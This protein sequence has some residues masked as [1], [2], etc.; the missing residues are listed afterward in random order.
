[1]T[2]DRFKVALHRAV[3][4]ENDGA[5]FEAEQIYQQ[6]LR[7]NANI[8]MLHYMYAQFLL[9]KGEYRAAWPHFLKRVEDTVYKERSAARLSKPYWDARDPDAEAGQTI[10]IYADQGLGDM[11]MCA[12]FLPAVAARFEKTV[13]M[14][15]PG[16]RA[17]LSS[18]P[19][20]IE[21]I[22]FGDPLPAFDVHADLFS[23]PALLDVLPETLPSPKCLSIDPSHIDAW[24]AGLDPSRLNVGLCWRGNPNHMRDAERSARL[25]DFRP[26]LDTGAVFHCLQ[27]GDAL[28]EIDDLPDTL[29]LVV[30]RKISESVDA[31]TGKM[32]DTAALASCMDLVISVDTAVVHL[33]GALGLPL[34]IFVPKCP[35]WRFMMDVEF[36]PW[37]PESRI[38]RCKERYD[39][40]HPVAEA[41]RRLMHM[42]AEKA[43][44]RP[45]T[46]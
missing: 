33:A 37:Y 38:F 44:G 36:S 25:A 9:R 35:D 22:E 7:Q 31:E 13:F 39:W 23:V 10:L 8:E 29:Q 2:N 18:L 41:R 11:L 15:Y 1:M 12:R 45:V 34:W 4:L 21:V 16:F 43:Q 14:V 3:G 46:P 17:L 20:E 6:L 32:I 30:H 24:R 19:P 28:Q 40:S 27:V 26:L 42:V 5:F